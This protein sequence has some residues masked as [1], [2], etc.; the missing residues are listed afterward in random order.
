MWDFLRLDAALQGLK[1]ME[2]PRQALTPRLSAALYIDADSGMSMVTA[3]DL[4]QWGVGFEEGMEIGLA[5]LAARSQEPFEKVADGLWAS[6]WGDCYDTARLLLPDKLREVEVD[7][8]LVA[9][10]PH[11]SALFLTGSNDVGGLGACLNTAAQQISEAPKPMS[12]QPMV[13]RYPGWEVL[14]FAR[15]HQLYDIWARARVYEMAGVYNDQQSALQEWCERQGDDV[16]VAQFNGVE[17]Q[18]TK[19]VRSYCVWSKDV[20][21][22]L[23]ETDEVMLYE[24]EKPEDDRVTRVDWDVMWAHC[25]GLLQ[26]TEHV[27]AR[28]RVEAFPDPETLR[29]MS[30]TQARRNGA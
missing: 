4:E 20:V 19:I 12:A 5:N 7:G 25:E 9:F 2:I 28:W 27:P 26:P 14:R 16:F 6:P 24:D 11:W 3:D 23:P 1:G 13:R 18:Q 10:C 29:R 8:D 15:G 21:T 30:E 22:F 17:E